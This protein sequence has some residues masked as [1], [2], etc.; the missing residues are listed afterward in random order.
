MDQSLFS[1]SS[2]VSEMESPK[3]LISPKSR[4]ELNSPVF[5]A[6]NVE[7]VDDIPTLEEEMDLLNQFLKKT[8][9]GSHYFLL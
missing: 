4:S 2:I 1:G 7:L 3:A 5:K 8:L 9:R 6:K